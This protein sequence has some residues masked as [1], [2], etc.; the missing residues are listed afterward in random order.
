M[1]ISILV[2]AIAASSILSIP[3]YAKDEMA[4]PMPVAKTTTQKDIIGKGTIV[5]ENKA[6][7]SVTLQHEAIPAI[8]WGAMTMEFKVKD[9]MQL[10]KVK[11]GDKVQFTLVPQGQDYVITSIK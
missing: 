10:D 2:L 9:K 4:M 6:G 11:K 1:K 7:G 3:A 8:G 5:S